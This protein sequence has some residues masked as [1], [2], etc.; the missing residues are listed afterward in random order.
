M[1]DIS[2]TEAMIKTFIEPYFPV[3]V[4]GRGS[5]KMQLCLP[6]DTKVRIMN[7]ADYISLKKRVIGNDEAGNVCC[8]EAYGRNV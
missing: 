3:L 7:P 6:D 8:K 5:G 4:M 1:Y 2:G